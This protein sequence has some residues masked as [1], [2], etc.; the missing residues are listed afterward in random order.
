VGN[1]EF[2]NDKGLFLGQSNFK[3]SLL[4]SAETIANLLKTINEYRNY[5]HPDSPEWMK[6]IQ[7]VF[8]ILGFHTEQKAPRLISLSDIGTIDSPKALVVLILP[9]E[10]L[11]EI[12][13]ELDWLSYLFYAANFYRV[14]WGFLTNGLEMKMYDFRRDDYRKIFLWASLDDIIRDGKLD[15]FYTIYKIFCYMRGVKGEV[16][17]SRRSQISRTGPPRVKKAILR[18]SAFVRNKTL[19]VEFENGRKNQWGLP[20][21]RDKDGIRKVRDIA[22]DF[23]R[24]NSASFGQMMAVKKAL[25]DAE[26]YVSR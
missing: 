12:T 20:D 7:E 25:T 21:Q 18:M 3:F 17:P 16:L 24:Q 22:V 13:P 8:H 1:N 2:I 4:D 15:S 26:Y 23:A 11:Q 10:N 5:A 14:N 19:F 6:Y 9:G